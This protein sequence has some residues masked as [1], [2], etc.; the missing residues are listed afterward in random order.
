MRPLSLGH[1][2]HVA[3]AA[4]F[5]AASV[6]ALATGGLRASWPTRSKPIVVGY[7]L[8]GGVHAQPA[9]TVKSLVESGAAAKLDQLNYSQGSVHA[10]RCQLMDPASELYLTFR[11]EQSVNGRAD[12]P[13]APLRGTFHQ[14]E[15]LKRR[16]PKIRILVSLE[17]KAEDFALAAQPQNRRAFVS[18]CVET[19]IRGRF[20]PHVVR[21]G[22]F[23]GIDV[24]WE[25]PELKDAANFHAL[26]A[27]F[28]RQM[29]AVRPGLKLAVAVGDSPLMLPGTDFAVVSRIVDQ[30][31]VM[32]YDYAGPWNTHTG[33]VAPL[34]LSQ[35]TPHSHESIAQSI[36]AYHKAGVPLK[37]MLMGLPFYGYSWT[38]VEEANHGLAQEGDSVR[39]DAPYHTIRALTEPFEAFRD[40]RSMAPWLFDGDTFWTYEDPVSVRYKVSYAA[41][42]KLAGIMIWELSGDSPNAELLHAAHWALHHPLG[43]KAFAETETAIMDDNGLQP[44]PTHE[45]SN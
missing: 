35:F 24:D 9:Y 10:A 11:A 45:S 42:Q 27:E 25:S 13:D 3:F 8:G 1:A 43:R 20:A 12:A 17:G 28:R 36:A 16:Y 39:E 6:P 19:F 38:R 22:I 2:L 7:F 40:P 33:F 4:L 30:V 34:F 44:P 29:N 5:L 41:R 15:E 14:L 32:N 21:P 23:D 31:G 18:S 26:L 37:K